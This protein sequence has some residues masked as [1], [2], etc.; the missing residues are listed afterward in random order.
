MY[1]DQCFDLADLGSGQPGRGRDPGRDQE[2]SQGGQS[3]YFSPP[4]QALIAAASS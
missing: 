4:A 2:Y 3:G 1:C